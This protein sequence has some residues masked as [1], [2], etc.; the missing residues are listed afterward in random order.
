[1]SDER[2]PVWPWIATGILFP[3][4]YVASIGPAC[5]ITS[6]TN[7]GE[8]ALQT[9]YRP[10]ISA[11]WHNKRVASAMTGYTSV[12]AT[13]PWHWEQSEHARTLYWTTVIFTNRSTRLG[14]SP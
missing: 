5:W 8:S 3:M 7:V 14:D 12:G 13:S 9:F 6:R 1:M 11:M 2:K 10:I 4:L